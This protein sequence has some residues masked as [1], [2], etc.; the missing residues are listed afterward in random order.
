M[1]NQINMLLMN[2]AKY[3]PE[4]SMPA[5]RQTLEQFGPEKASQVLGTEYKDP[6]IA[7][8]L[9][10]VIGEFGVDR[11]YIGDITMGAIKLVVFL[12]ALTITSLSCGI[13]FF[14]P[15]IWPIID[16]FLIM[17][18]TKEKNYQKFMQNVNYL[19]QS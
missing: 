11:F 18:A 15:F 12:I 3:F 13:L 7:L 10:I 4:A 1:D 19:K 16:M 5:I 14:L 9:S 17:G 6:T 2:S 8:I